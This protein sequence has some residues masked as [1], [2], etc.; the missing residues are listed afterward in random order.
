MKNLMNWL[1]LGIVAIAIACVGAAIAAIPVMLLWN[2]LMPLIFGL[3]QLTF[4]EA[5]GVSLL[6]SILFKSSSGSSSKD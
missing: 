4:L 1:I 2:W 3:K 5:L 6:S